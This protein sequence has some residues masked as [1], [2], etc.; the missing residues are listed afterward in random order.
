MNGT[1][2]S[3][4]EHILQAELCT[5]ER[6]ERFY[7]RQM[8]TSLNPAMIEFVG[9][10]DLMFIATADAAGACDVSLRAG[11]PGFVRVLAPDV[12]AYPEYR[13]NGVMAS[14]GNIVENPHVG[15]M[16]VDFVTDQ[17]GLHINGSATVV[18]DAALR[19]RHP[20]LPRARIPD[21]VAARWVLIE[22]EE[23]YIH[24]SRHIPALIPASRNRTDGTP[25]EHRRGGN[26]FLVDARPGSDAQADITGH[27]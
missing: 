2:G 11:P 15:L 24:C 23:A 7:T 9:Q 26:Y 19:E 3:R 18:S 8:L 27:P 13:G 16:L 14:M 22:V 4:G 25:G 10:R 6:A 17:I 20:D 1:P 21:Q 12:L 5:E